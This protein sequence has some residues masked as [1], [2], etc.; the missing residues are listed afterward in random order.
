[1]AGFA[2]LVNMNALALDDPVVPVVP[3][4]LA[5]APF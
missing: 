4:G 2:A 1:V 5:A 3:L